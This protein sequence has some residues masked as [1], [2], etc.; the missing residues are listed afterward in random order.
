MNEYMVFHIFLLFSLN[1]E[2]LNPGYFGY[3]AI[4]EFQSASARGRGKAFDRTADNET[5]LA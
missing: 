4:W 1:P 2:C 3:L 5:G